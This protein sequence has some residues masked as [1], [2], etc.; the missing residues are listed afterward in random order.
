MVAVRWAW[1]PPKELL[2]QRRHRLSLSDGIAVV[3]GDPLAISRPDPHADGDRW[4][5]VGIAHGVALLFVVHTEPIE[6]EDGRV[7]GRIISV[8]R[9]TQYERKAYEDGTL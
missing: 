1:D 6:Y 2:N 3:D 4:Q 8:R 5:T 7:V 9:A